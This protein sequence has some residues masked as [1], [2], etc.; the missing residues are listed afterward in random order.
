MEK[1]FLMAEMITL[2]SKFDGAEFGAL[3]KAA[4]GARKGGVI[5][6]QEIFG[7]DQYIK[8]DVARWASLG[9]EAL[10]PSMFDR[11]EKGFTAEH[12]PEDMPRAFGAM[13]NTPMDQAVADIDACIEF[14]APRGPVFILGYCYGGSMSFIAATQ[15]K[16]LSAASCYYGSLLPGK[17]ADVPLCPTIAHFGRLDTY[18][19][20]DTVEA[21][22]AARP[23]VPTYDYEAGH[24]FNNEGGQAY[25]AEAAELARTRTLELFA[26]NGAA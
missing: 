18:I 5:I 7:I 26:A 17:A 22:R 2:T 4:D 1:A 20:M 9:F 12:S 14:L 16:G 21:F 23:D 15:L 13:Q 8:A 10:A 3:H 19:P 6:I 25:S 24:G 11:I